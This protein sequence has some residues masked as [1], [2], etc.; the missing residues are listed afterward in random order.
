MNFND[1]IEQKTKEHAYVLGAKAFNQKTDS[2]F[3][4]GSKEDEE[5]REGYLDGFFVSYGYNLDD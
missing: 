3:T 5:W 2:P 1:V 4:K